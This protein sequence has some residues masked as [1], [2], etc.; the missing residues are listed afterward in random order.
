LKI[1]VFRAA[2][3][4]LSWVSPPVA[5]IIAP[6]IAFLLWY[7][8]PRKRRVTRI[9]LRAVYPDMDAQ[10]RNRIARASMTHYVRGA[11]EAG[12]LW[13][14]PLER[15]FSYFDESKDLELYEEA[16]RSGSAVLM[17]G[18]H[19]GAW[20]LLVLY[21]QH[22]MSSAILYKPARDPEI[23]EMLLE[24]RERG[25][26][27]MIP[28]NAAGLRAMFKLLKDGRTV[29]MAPDQEPTLGEGQFAPFFGVETLTGVLLPRLAQRTGA[30]VIFGI[31]ERVKGGR[32]RIRTFKADETIYDKDIRTA[33]TAVNQGIEQCIEVDNTQYLWAYK[34]FRN[35]PD[36]GKSF[37][38]R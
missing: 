13:H 1:L 36:G 18:T 38:K 20:E 3:R 33:V 5:E 21:V 15:I 16:K 4:L 24:K 27:S 6:P 11:F 35:R 12:M 29:S 7:M 14:W 22:F 34:R 28:A 10:S 30:P 37:Y 32:Y 26:A 2:M 25:G 23:E 17:A 19:G 9:N 31:C 8:S